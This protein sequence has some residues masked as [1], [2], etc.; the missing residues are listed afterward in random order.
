MSLS[1]AERYEVIRLV[2]E[3]QLSVKQT[4]RE[5]GIARSTFYRWYKAYQEHGYD[6]LELGSKAPRRFWN[7]L[8]ES[9]KEQC[10][11][12]ALAHPE[13]SPRELAWHITDKHAYFISES[14]VYRLLKQY[15]LITSPAYILLQASDRFHTPTRRINELWQT[16]FTYFRIVGW[17]WYFLSTVLDDYSRYI[18]SWKLTTTMAADDVKLTLDDAISKTGT[19]QVIV[20]H[21]PRLLSDNGPCYLSR[22]LK[23]YLKQ[24]QMDHTRGAPYH[25][26]TQGKI[27]R[28]HRSMK[29]IVKLE[30]Y[31]YPWELEEAIRRFVEYYNN[32]RLHEALDNVTPADMFYSRYEKIMDRRALIKQQTL[33]RRREENLATCSR[34]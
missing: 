23:H 9:V 24:Q 11:E 3:S 27:E 1:A 19:D 21:R 12:E 10:I 34:H 13:K 20:K 6:G 22:D 33:Q 18:I 31:Y 14:S 26:Q 17:G 4:L 2:E 29:N 15:D 32:E 30:N 25:P 28:Y 5:L 16:D 8:P 7:R